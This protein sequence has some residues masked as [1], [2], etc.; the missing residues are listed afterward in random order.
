MTAAIPQCIQWNTLQ[1][2]GFIDDCITGLPSL[3]QREWLRR[4]R[5][6]CAK[7]QDWGNLNPVAVIDHI[8]QK[9]A[10][11]ARAE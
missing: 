3:K 10:E 5:G 8:D 4:Y 6:A 9:L 7:R 2:L 11:L 1:E